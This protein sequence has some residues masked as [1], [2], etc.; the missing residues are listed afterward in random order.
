MAKFSKVKVALMDS[1]FDP[2][3][4]VQSITMNT[5]MDAKIELSMDYCIPTSA[6]SK[7]SLMVSREQMAMAYGEQWGA[8]QAQI[9]LEQSS[10][11]YMADMKRVVGI[12]GPTAS[13]LE[14]HEVNPNILDITMTESNRRAVREIYQQGDIAD[15]G[16]PVIVKKKAIKYA[17]SSIKTLPKGE[18]AESAGVRREGWEMMENLRKPQIAA[19]EAS[20]DP[21][22][23]E[24]DS[25]Y[26]S[27]NLLKAKSDWEAEQQRMREELSG[28]SDMT[29]EIPRM[30]P[31]PAP[32][33]P[34]V[35]SMAEVLG[36]K[37]KPSAMKKKGVQF[38]V[39]GV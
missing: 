11:P 20:V 28:M 33:R 7:L 30:P 8:L 12:L 29:E 23:S 5:N 19:E 22:D 14:D 15:E 27:A 36:H 2:P 21:T 37:P 34:R 4:E 6:A 10:F 35:D 16:D 3:A 32:L 24:A 31:P 17:K 18:L 9:T 13:A 38:N 26:T 39:S 1:R 25:D